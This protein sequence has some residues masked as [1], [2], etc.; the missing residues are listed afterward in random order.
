MFDENW[1]IKSYKYVHRAFEKEDYFEEILQFE[2]S[3]FLLKIHSDGLRFLKTPLISFHTFF[4]YGLAFL[5]PGTRNP[6]FN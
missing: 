1:I 3:L 2:T 6:N 5:A 4:K